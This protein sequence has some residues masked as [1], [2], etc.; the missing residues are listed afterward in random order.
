MRFLVNC[1]RIL[2]PRGRLTKF[3]CIFLLQKM[4]YSTLPRE[5][6][7]IICEYMFELRGI[8]INNTTTGGMIVEIYMLIR[9]LCPR[10]Q[11]PRRVL[12]NIMFKLNDRIYQ[13]QKTCFKTKYF[14]LRSPGVEGLK[15]NAN[16]MFI[17]NTEIEDRTLRCEFK[18]IPELTRTPGG[19]YYCTFDI[20]I[21]VIY[22]HKFD[23]PYRMLCVLINNSYFILLKKIL[24][25]L[26]NICIDFTSRKIM[27]V[28]YDKCAF[29]DSTDGLN[30]FLRCYCC[31]FIAD[32]PERLLETQKN[33]YVTPGVGW[34][35]IIFGLVHNEYRK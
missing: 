1:R 2:Q 9:S 17:Y 25:Q 8:N 15:Y 5:L 24:Q 32:P 4:S 21:T 13:T 11:S 34:S 28:M 23:I 7:E 12:D 14:L 30:Y 20:K 29:C 19:V 33:I 16:S 10:E 18:N 3:E 26:R 6:H 27:R 35:K 22:K 31:E